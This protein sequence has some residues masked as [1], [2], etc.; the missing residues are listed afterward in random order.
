M[1]APPGAGRAVSV[2]LSTLVAGAAMAPAALAGP[3]REVDLTFLGRTTPPGGEGKAEIAAFDPASNRVFVTNAT[4]NRVDIYDFTDPA[5]PGAAIGSIEMTPFG[6]GPNSVAIHDGLVAVAQEGATP[7]QTGS[8]QFFGTDGVRL[9]SV[10]AG[11]LPDMLTFTADGNFL[12][13]ANEGEP[14]DDGIVDPPGTVTVIDMRGGLDDMIVRHAGFGGVA[15]RGPVRT[16]TPGASI[17]QDLEPEYVTTQG[18]T[19]YVSIQEANAVGILDIPTARFRVVRGLGFKDWSRSRLDTSNGDD[20]GILLRSWD[21]L[22]GMYQPDAIAAYALGKRKNRRIYVATANEGD[23]RDFA[24]FSEQAEVA[25]LALDPTAFPAGAGDPDQLGELKV[26]NTQGDTDG[27]GDYDKLYAFGG[28]SLS[29]L[30]AGG[31]VAYDT[32]GQLERLAARL[33][34][35]NFNK[36]NVPGSAVD[37]RSDDKG[38][39]PEALAVGRVAGR[40]YAFVAAERSG[41][42]YA[43]DLEAR[44]GKATYADAYLNTREADLGPEGA[45]VVPAR[46]SP[47]GDPMLLIAYEVSSTVAAYSITPE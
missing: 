35:A 21:N 30:G 19:A 39:E 29:I 11:A 2:F 17:A 5:A 4:D 31:R 16:F 26:T 9:G 47:T 24:F 45:L 10:R 23:A 18:R 7:Q 32:G 14:S 3:P 15:L 1:K 38:P 46:K 37:N 28:R 22:F 40:K 8:V 41:G 33:D 44:R 42:I 13:V 34:A 36:S 43:Y 27:D 12:L 25:D 20:G 6:G